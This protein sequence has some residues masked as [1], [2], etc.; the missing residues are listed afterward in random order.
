MQEF[1]GL[2]LALFG[3]PGFGSLAEVQEEVAAQG[4]LGNAEVL[5]QRGGR[6]V[7]LPG[8]CGPGLDV[9]E[10]GVVHA[11]SLR[12]MIHLL[13]MHREHARQAHFRQALA[14]LAAIRITTGKV[15][16]NHANTKLPYLQY[17]RSKLLILFSHAGKE[18]P[19]PSPD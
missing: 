9:F 3:E 19:A 1:D 6:P 10:A 18:L 7:G 15:V 17:I 14:E 4:V 13:V 2:L 16:P 12:V 5:G 11:G 8:Q